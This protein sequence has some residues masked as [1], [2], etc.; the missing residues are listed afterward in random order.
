MNVDCSSVIFV[1]PVTCSEWKETR[2]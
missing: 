1:T 2:F